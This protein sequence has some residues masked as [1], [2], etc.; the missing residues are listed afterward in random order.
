[1]EIKG[2]VIEKL[3][4]QSGTSS[5]GEW[6][7]ATIVV[8]IPDGQYGI[9]LALDNL[10]DAD[11]FDKIA[12][13]SEGT[14]NVNVSSRKSNDGRWFTSCTCWRWNIEGGS[15]QAQPT[16]VAQPQPTPQVAPVA[17]DDDQPF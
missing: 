17:T 10:K 12:V 13:G 16:Q 9:K 6:K 4:L 3:P 2:K 14:F 15:E 1:M 11:A 7:K 5:R 8:E